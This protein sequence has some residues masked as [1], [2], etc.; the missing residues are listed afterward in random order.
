[1]QAAHLIAGAVQ[2][3]FKKILMKNFDD[4]RAREPHGIR[5]D[6]SMNQSGAIGTELN[7]MEPGIHF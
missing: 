2:T 3:L 1:M 6:T 7:R 4:R 5:A